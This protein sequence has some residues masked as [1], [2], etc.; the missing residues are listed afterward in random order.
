MIL[1]DIETENDIILDYG[2]ILG[3][4]VPPKERKPKVEDNDHYS[5]KQ[6]EEKSEIEN[7]RLIEEPE[8]NTLVDIPQTYFT[9]A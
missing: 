7:Q 2:L 4:I 1:K 5:E 8:K 9:D 3:T 6:K